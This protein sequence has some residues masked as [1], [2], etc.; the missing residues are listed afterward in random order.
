MTKGLVNL[1]VER[2][3]VERAKGL[4]INL[5]QHFDEFLAHLLKEDSAREILTEKELITQLKIQNAKLISQLSE[6][7]QR[8]EG[9]EKKEKVLEEIKEEKIEQQFKYSELINHE[10][11]KHMLKMVKEKGD[12]VIDGQ[13]KRLYNVYGLKLK[14]YEFEALRNY[15]SNK[16]E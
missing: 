3:N 11:V 5:S 9:L 2:G 16:E 14:R 13:L 12:R 10:G 6:L 7:N 1:Y 4:G 8:I 15:L